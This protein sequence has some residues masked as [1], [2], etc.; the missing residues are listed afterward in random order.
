MNRLLAR[1]Q[2]RRNTRRRQ[3]TA[4]G[5]D[6]GRERAAN[7]YSLIGTATLCGLDPQTYSQHVLTRIAEHPITRIDELLRC[8]PGLW[9]HNSHLSRSCGLTHEFLLR[10][11]LD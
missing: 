8:C 6:T 10:C 5:A 2:A 3:L 7:L 11:N 4:Y 9:S 1:S